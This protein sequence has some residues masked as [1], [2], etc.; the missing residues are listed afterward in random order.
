[1]GF[2]YLNLCTDHVGYYEKYGFQY[3]GQGYYLWREEAR[4]YQV[5]I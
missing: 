4:I 3:I 5:N 2:N 1:M